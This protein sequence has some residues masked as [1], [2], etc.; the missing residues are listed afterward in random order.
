MVSAVRSRQPAGHFSAYKFS[1]ACTGPMASA[2]RFR[3]PAGHFSANGRSP[4]EASQREV[5]KSW[6]ARGCQSE[7]NK[8][9]PA[10]GFQSEVFD[11]YL[12]VFEKYRAVSRCVCKSLARP[13]KFLA[14]P[15]ASLRATCFLARPCASLRGIVLGEF[16][17]HR[18]EYY[19]YYYYDL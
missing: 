10:R 6:P 12:K 17:F 18:I 14:R 11:K 8:S 1:G 7:V 9:W 15:C 3:Q 19:Y 13:D 16:V 2:V 4:S 5:N